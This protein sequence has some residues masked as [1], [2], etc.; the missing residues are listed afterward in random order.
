MDVDVCHGERSRAPLLHCAVFA[1]RLRPLYSRRRHAGDA[2]RDLERSR[3]RRVS[4]SAAVRPSTDLLRQLR[5]T[6]EPVMERGGK[7]GPAV[8]M[9]IPTLNEAEAIGPL[10]A[11]VPRD[12]VS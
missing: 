11:R 6:L 3:L 12:I 7:F 10:I 1:T 4:H 9:V 2:A 5:P 8:A